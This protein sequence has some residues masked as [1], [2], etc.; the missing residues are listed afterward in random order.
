MATGS[1]VSVSLEFERVV[2]AGRYTDR[3][4]RHA[5]DEVQVLPDGV[6]LPITLRELAQALPQSKRLRLELVL[7]Q[8]L[9]GRQESA[10]LRRPGREAA[11]AESE[12]GADGEGGGVQ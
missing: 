2:G 5:L 4:G 3:P 7:G 11:R 8:G 10:S 9:N 12:V 1:G 6:V